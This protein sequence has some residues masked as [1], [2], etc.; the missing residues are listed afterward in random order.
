MILRCNLLPYYAHSS[1]KS[2]MLMS[3]SQ[4]ELMGGIFIG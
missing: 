2:G 4:R 1:Y 3:W